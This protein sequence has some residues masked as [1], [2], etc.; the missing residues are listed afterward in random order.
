MAPTLVY[1]GLALG[2]DGQPLPVSML[3]GIKVPVA[4]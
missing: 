3:G 4:A 1:D 2:G